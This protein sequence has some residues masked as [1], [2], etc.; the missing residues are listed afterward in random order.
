MYCTHTLIC[1]LPN[2]KQPSFGC[3]HCYGFYFRLMS[4]EVRHILRWHRETLA[5]LYPVLNQG[6]L[7]P[8]QQNTKCHIPLTRNTTV[9][10]WAL[11]FSFLF[12]PVGFSLKTRAAV[13]K[14][15]AQHWKNID[16]TPGSIAQYVFCP[17]LG[18]CALFRP[19]WLKAMSDVREQGCFT[20]GVL[21]WAQ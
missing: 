11:R 19:H 6:K 8:Q 18:F 15:S 17:W 10:G 5:S 7:K 3:T 14:N 16:L 21:V 1:N 2:I 12:V 4:M 13:P 20:A 9:A